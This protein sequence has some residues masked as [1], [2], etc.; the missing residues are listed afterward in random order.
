MNYLLSYIIRNVV[1]VG[2]ILLLVVVLVVVR[3]K[4]G[5]L[6]M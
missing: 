3:D 1:V 2:V 4:K 6:I 5:N